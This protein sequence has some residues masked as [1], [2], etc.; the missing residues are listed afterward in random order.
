MSLLDEANVTLP[1]FHVDHSPE[2]M[3]RR[4]RWYLGIATFRHGS[5]GLFCLIMPWL[6][7][8]AAFIPVLDFLPIW[9][10]GTVMVA[11]SL[12]CGMAA[13]LRS[14]DWA[15][16]SMVIS[17][18]IT[19]VLAV[20]VLI[21]VSIV[22]WQWFMGLRPDPSSPVLPIVLGSL[23]AKDFVVCAQPIRSPFESVVHLVTGE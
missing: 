21:G 15:R 22:W 16:W 11:C 8:A 14:G 5:L 23:A 13:F 17:A 20:G 12:L 4:A 10:W 6:F 3:T 19:T 1:T 9:G 7:G 18:T 2:A